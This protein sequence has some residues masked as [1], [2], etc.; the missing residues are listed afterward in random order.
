MQQIEFRVSGMSCTGCEQRIQK[1]LSRVD[2]VVRSSADHHAGRVRVVFDPTR[3]SKEAVR[4][5]IE[6]AGYEVSL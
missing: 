5:C 2:G 1:A 4:S 3:T 6:R